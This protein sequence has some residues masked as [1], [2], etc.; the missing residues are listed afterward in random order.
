MYQQ[1]I[2]NA[3]EK[4]KKTTSVFQTELRSIRAG[5]ANRKRTRNGGR[6]IRICG[7]RV[8]FNI[9]RRPLDIQC[10]R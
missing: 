4:M 5:R 6:C 9:C 2:D 10:E 1:V 7:I 3:T 8:C